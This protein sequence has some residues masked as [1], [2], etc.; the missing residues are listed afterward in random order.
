MS[1]NIKYINGSEY[2]KEI[3][4]GLVIVDWY[5]SEC[6][7]CEALAA[8][9]EPLSEIYGDHIKFLKIFRQENRELSEALD[10]KSSPTVLF[11]KDGQLIGDRLNGGVK[12][13]EIE[14]TLDALLSPDTV[15]Q[16]KD[17][18]TIKK[19]DCDVLILGGG[20]SGLAA[21]IYTAQANLDTI[22]VDPALPGGQVKTTHLVSNYPGFIEPVQGFMLA[23][24]MSEQAKEAGADYRAA[25]DITNI[26]F[27]NLSVSIDN[28]ETISAKKIILAS[29]ASPRPL[30]IPGEVK[31]KGQGISY[32]ATCDAKYY[33]DKEVIV[34][35]GGNSAIEE[36]LFIAKFASKITI[37]HQFSELQAN[38][39]AQEKSFAEEKINF[40]FEHEPREFIKAETGMDVLVEDLKSSETKKISADGV[41]VFVGMKPNIENIADQFDLDDWGYVKTDESMKSSIPNVYAVG[42]VRSKMYRQITTA[43]S[44]GTIASI[45]ISKEL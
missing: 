30:G 3:S 24:Y 41:F 36:A 16:I 19:T 45:A 40:I 42:D 27:K 13:S 18:L 8:K 23:H 7:P 17:S 9:Y 29:G 6:P 5:S 35:G 38:K 44:D 26:D 28:I 12:R 39:Q 31:Y 33:K 34:I 10:I 32:C 1:A 2:D 43:V 14:K 25:V 15:K 11:Y 20:P 37:I 21:G 4:E 22:I